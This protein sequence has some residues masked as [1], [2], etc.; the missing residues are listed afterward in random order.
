[1]LFVQEITLRYQKDVR[2][3]NYAN[4]R[5]AVRFWELPEKYP[6]ENETFFQTVFMWQTPEK[7]S[8]LP[9]LFEILR[10]RGLLWR[11]F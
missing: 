6:E 2:Y 3:A 7:V 4:Q 11:W 5:R 10:N 9:E 1:M 8:L